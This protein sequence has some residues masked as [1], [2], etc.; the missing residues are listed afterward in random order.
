MRGR[1]MRTSLYRRLFTWYH[2]SYD[3]QIYNL[4]FVPDVFYTS[5]ATLTRPLRSRVLALAW[6]GPHGS[7][8]FSPVGG[9]RLYS[10]GEPVNVLSRKGKED[11]RNSWRCLRSTRKRTTCS[12]LA[13]ISSTRSGEG[14]FTS[15]KICARANGPQNGS[16][17]CGG[18]LESLVRSTQKGHPPLPQGWVAGAKCSRGP[19][20]E[21]E[22][23][24][25][26]AKKEKNEKKRK[27]IAKYVFGILAVLK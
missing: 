24:Q 14:W 19:P 16:L 9:N 7:W 2:M 1:S 23:K 4:Q 21:R 22:G 15:G 26:K 5:S 11:C 8:G 25:E 18:A 17:R 27:I 3:A 6:L 10:E 13:W 20:L 12:T